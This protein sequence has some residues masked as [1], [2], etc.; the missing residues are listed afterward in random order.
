MN[1]VLHATPFIVKF[2]DPAAALESPH[3]TASSHH[4][5]MHAIF[6]E[7]GTNDAYNLTLVS[8]TDDYIAGQVW[9]DEMNA[10]Y[11]SLQ[12]K[13][14]TL[15]LATLAWRELNPMPL[16]VPPA[17]LEFPLVPTDRPATMLERDEKHRVN[18]ENFLRNLAARGPQRG[19]ARQEAKFSQEWLAGNLT[20]EEK[21]MN[22]SF[23]EKFWSI[24]PVAWHVVK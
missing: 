17:L 5:Q 11:R 13:R 19:W 9:V 21:Q 4:A 3:P 16:L 15:I 1:S 14:Q 7:T 10:I 22:E 2:T 24:R 12:R 20:E 8:V 6:L 18:N 23:D